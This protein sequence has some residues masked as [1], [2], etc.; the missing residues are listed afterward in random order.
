MC[1][2]RTVL[3]TIKEIQEHSLEVSS[4]MFSPMLFQSS[5]FQFHYLELCEDLNS[6]CLQACCSFLQLNAQ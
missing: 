4:L 1:T 3:H 2:E 6:I 5:L